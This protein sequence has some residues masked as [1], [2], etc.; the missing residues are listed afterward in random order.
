V[1]SAELADYPGFLTHGR[2]WAFVREKFDRLGARYTTPA[3]R[4]R[5]VA[6]VSELERFPVAELTGLLGG[7]ALPMVSAATGGRT[8]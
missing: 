6:T 4:D 7:A 2:T 3:L 1:L 8:R 5:I